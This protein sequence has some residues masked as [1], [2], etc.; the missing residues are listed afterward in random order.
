MKVICQERR[1]KEGN[2]TGC[3]WSCSEHQVYSER[4]DLTEE[5]FIKLV[6]LCLARRQEVTKENLLD[7]WTRDQAKI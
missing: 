3:L 2:L 5:R 6:E 4:R 1:D 7:L